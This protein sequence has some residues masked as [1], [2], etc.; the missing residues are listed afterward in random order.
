MTSGVAVVTHARAGRVRLRVALTFGAATM[1]GAFLGGTLARYA[2][3]EHLVFGFGTV[4]IITGAMML[5]PRR[6]AAGPPPPLTRGRLARTL[7]LGFCV[8][9]LTGTVGAGGGF[10]IVP[11]LVFFGRLEM[12][13]AVATSLL[14][15][16]LNCMAGLAG[17]LGHVEIDWRLAGLCTAAAVA[18]SFIGVRLGG[19]VSQARLRQLFGGLAVAVG[20]YLMVRG[21]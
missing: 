4:L 17:Y 19:R 14:V 18:G 10:L 12:R 1:L 6:E 11:A 2:R 3:G 15:I 21:S 8:G 9:L 7:L 20:V 16:A 5:R 13:E